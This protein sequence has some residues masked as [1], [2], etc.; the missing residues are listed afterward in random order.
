MHLA[1]NSWFLALFLY[2]KLAAL[3]YKI[4]YKQKVKLQG[5]LN[6]S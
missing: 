2:S 3:D 5:K 4:E 6:V 1:S